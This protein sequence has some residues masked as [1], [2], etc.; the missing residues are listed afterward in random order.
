MFAVR[1]CAEDD[2]VTAVEH[3][4]VE[5]GLEPAVD[6]NAKRLT[7]S[8]DFAH[9]ELRVVVP[10][11]TESGKHGAG[12][13][14]EAVAIA[15][16]VLPRN[17]PAR[18]VQQCSLA[19]K[20]RGD[21]HAHPRAAP[22]HARDETYV[23]LACVALQNA[24][25][26]V[27]PRATQPGESCPGDAG[28]RILHRRYDARHARRDQRFRAGRR[29]AVMTA[30]LKGEIDRGA[31]RSVAGSAQ[32]M[33]LGMGL[34]GA[35]VPALAYN[36]TILDDDTSNP[37]IRGRGIEATLRKAKRACHVAVVIR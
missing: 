2:D 21:F 13:G 36:R 3:P 27:D 19:V 7:G 18:A 34:S 4:R 25:F 14:T 5:L 37:R 33:D 35:F 16:S 15:T 22:C 12:A 1:R 10:H 20:A 28:I 17:P 6:H 11:G 8:L 31:P 24:A 26:R 23:E 30:G 29:A 9:R 32:R